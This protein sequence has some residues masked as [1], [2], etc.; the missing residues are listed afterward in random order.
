M[1]AASNYNP[2]PT[3]AI[4]TP[5]AT[6]IC[7]RTSDHSCGADA[8]GNLPP[9]QSFLAGWSSLCTASVPAAS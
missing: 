4:I 6:V 9:H 2:A 3:A 1:I 8:T 7:T 5:P